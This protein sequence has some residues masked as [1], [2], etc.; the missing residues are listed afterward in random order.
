[1]PVEI[2][3]EFRT[4]ALTRRET[5]ALATVTIRALL[6]RYRL[7]HRTAV[8]VTFVDNEQMRLY[9]KKYMNKP[10]PTDVLAFP[11]FEGPPPADAPAPHLGDVMV[12]VDQA[13]LQAAERGHSTAAEVR[14]LLV[15]GFLHLLG[16][17]DTTPAAKR[18]MD[19]ETR[20]CLK[21]MGEK[22]IL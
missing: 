3:N 19:E 12:S 7:P 2:I 10:V 5:R 22:L 8:G 1:M 15:H 13:A 6:A 9:N 18:R 21:A 14:L 16:H 11:L 4:K 17:D 20:A